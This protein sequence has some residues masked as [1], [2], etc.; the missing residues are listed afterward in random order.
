[1]TSAN[2]CSIL[3]KSYVFPEL[4]LE[5]RQ[6]CQNA[7]I[8]MVASGDYF[9]PM[10]S[11]QLIRPSFWFEFL[12]LD[13]HIVADLS[14]AALS[15]I[16]LHNQLPEGYIN[17]ALGLLN[18]LDY[19]KASRSSRALNLLSTLD[20]E[21]LGFKGM[22]RISS[23]LHP[24]INWVRDHPELEQ[25]ILNALPNVQEPVSSLFSG[26]YSCTPGRWSFVCRAKAK[27]G[28]KEGIA[29]VATFDFDQATNVCTYKSMDG[30]GCALYT[31]CSK[32][33]VHIL[34]AA[35]SAKNIAT[36]QGIPV[37]SLF[38]SPN[39]GGECCRFKHDGE[40]TKE[41]LSKPE[42]QQ[43]DGI[44]VVHPL[45]VEVKKSRVSSYQNTAF[46]LKRDS[47]SSIM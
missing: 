6:K 38:G 41:S 9:L 31:I 28:S 32:P 39:V 24:K 25:K 37:K 11:L 3:E 17:F 7:I 34:I 10:E 12:N 22:A 43:N 16:L 33:I 5:F 2:C 45:A 18:W 14:R 13:Y 26:L 36:I 47:T 1:M 15:T 21:A 29:I 44:T 46:L 40:A 8:P 20:F 23:R 30:S 42:V 35:G 27:A 4:S 19:K